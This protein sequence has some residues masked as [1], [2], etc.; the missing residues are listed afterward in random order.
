VRDGER[1]GVGSGGDE[2]YPFRCG[3]L[4]LSARGHGAAD[5]RQLATVPLPIREGADAE[6]YLE[7]LL[8]AG[9]GGGGGRCRRLIVEQA[10]DGGGFE[11]SGGEGSGGRPRAPR[12][13]PADGGGR[14]G[15]RTDRCIHPSPKFVKVELKRSR[16][17]L[18]NAAH[19]YKLSLSL[20]WTGP[21]IILW[22]TLKKLLLSPAPATAS[23]T[24]VTTSS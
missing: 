8:A 16:F 13:I 22:A 15:R 3:R 21:F 12:R 24:A 10:G 11:F 1:N 2:A 7:A 20:S 6:E 19:L 17:L 23:T 18:P 9:G 14:G 5:V 4:G